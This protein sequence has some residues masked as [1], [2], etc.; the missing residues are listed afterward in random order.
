MVFL[1]KHAVPCS[2]I[3][4]KSHFR[5]KGLKYLRK[6]SWSRWQK[7]CSKLQFFSWLPFT[8]KQ[9]SSWSQNSQN[10]K[11]TSEKCN[12]STTI[13]SKYYCELLLKNNSAHYFGIVYAGWMKILSEWIMVWLE[14]IEQRRLYGFYHPGELWGR[15]NCV[16]GVSAHEILSIN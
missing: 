16:V 4:Y 9:F 6:F 3:Y 7:I 2:D 14:T 1:L 11:E 13:V 15:N 10:S 12:T 5:D 8:I